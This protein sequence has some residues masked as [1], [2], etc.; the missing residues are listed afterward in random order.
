MK[1]LFFFF[2]TPYTISRKNSQLGESPAIA[3][4]ISILPRTQN[5]SHKCQWTSRNIW[6]WS[7]LLCVS[8]AKYLIAQI[9]SLLSDQ[10]VNYCFQAIIMIPDCIQSASL[11]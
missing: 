9:W 8:V 5:N 2:F 11:F 10:Q 3:L 6:A 1:K 4:M 7:I